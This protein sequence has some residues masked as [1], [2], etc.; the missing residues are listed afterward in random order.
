MVNVSVFEPV[1][2]TV[3]YCTR[4]TTAWF[5]DRLITAV[6]AYIRL[7]VDNAHSGDAFS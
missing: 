4:A 3:S 5:F 1:A 6:R 7:P 2:D